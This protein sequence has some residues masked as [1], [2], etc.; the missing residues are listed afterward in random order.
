MVFAISHAGVMVAINLNSGERVWSRDI[1]G[2]QTPWA[3][4]DFVYVTTTDGLLLCL[5]RKDG[6][7]KWM[8]HLQRWADPDS[9][10]G[11]ITWAG[12]VLV[13]DRLV[14]VSSVGTAVSIS[15]YTGHLRGSAEIPAGAY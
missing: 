3:A 11:P 5:A 7:V 1:G 2:I 13:S 15:P 6:R 12:P 10:D 14:L 8:H 9:K 4:G